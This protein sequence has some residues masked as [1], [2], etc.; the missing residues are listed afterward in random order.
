M[1]NPRQPA[2]QPGWPLRLPAVVGGVDRAAAQSTA[3]Y[4]GRAGRVAGAVAASVRRATP[5]PRS[6]CPVRSGDRVCAARSDRGR[7]CDRA[8]FCAHHHHPQIPA[9]VDNG[10]EFGVGILEPLVACCAL[11]GNV[12]VA[13]ARGCSRCVGRMA[14]ANRA[15][16]SGAGIAGLGARAGDC[17]LDQHPTVAARCPNRRCGRTA[18]ASAGAKNVA[19]F[20]DVCWATGPVVTNRQLPGVSARADRASHLANQHWLD[21]AVYPIGL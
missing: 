1:E 2:T 21:V 9:A 15:V 3:G 18:L 19:L 6:L 14:E 12:L 13:V 11:G 8:R 16:L 5:A 7:R 10:C 20:R 4:L 17:A